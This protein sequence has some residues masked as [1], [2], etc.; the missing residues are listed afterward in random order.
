MLEWLWFLGLTVAGLALCRKA[1]ELE[2]TAD[3]DLA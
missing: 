1:G 3:L 2:E